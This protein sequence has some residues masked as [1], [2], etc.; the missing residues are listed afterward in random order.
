V[1][2]KPTVSVIIPAFNSE[3]TIARALLSVQEQTNGELEVIVVDD[4]STDSTAEKVAAF[5]GNV[6]YIRIENSGPAAARNVG[7]AHSHGE[8]VA[9]LD[10]D[11]EW[12][13]ERL[14][15]CLKPMLIDSTVGL[16]YCWSMRRRP[17]GQEEIRNIRSPS[18]NPLHMSFWPDPM[19]TTPATTC[20]RSMLDK[21]GLFDEK[22]KT[23]EDQDLWI[24]LSE[25]AKIAAIP[26]PLV[27]TH[28]RPGS[29]SSQQKYAQ[30]RNDYFYILNKA[31]QRAPDKYEKRRNLLLAEAY[32][33]WGLYALYY[34]YL[35]EARRDLSRSLRLHFSMSTAFYA[36]VAY[37]IPAILLKPIRKLYRI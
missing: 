31:F 16:T 22:L 29:Y 20:R 14:N 1:S 24:R 32:R 19:Q 8:Y 37:L 36:A 34:G 12:L 5:G 7:I 4:G 30:L 3:A 18:R 2:N 35:P 13:P 15:R 26:I 9:F 10:A 27:I 17:N 21:A 6:H 23:R 28:S 11:D 25:V 33:Y